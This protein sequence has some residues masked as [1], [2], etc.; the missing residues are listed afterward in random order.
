MN[1]FKN[2]KLLKESYD[3]SQ[4]NFSYDQFMQDNYE[5]LK[6]LKEIKYPE[7]LQLNAD[8]TNARGGSGDYNQN[9]SNKERTGVTDITYGVS[10]GEAGDRRF[11]FSVPGDGWPNSKER[12][13]VSIK[14]DNEGGPT[15]E[16]LESVPAKDRLKMLDVKVK[17]DCP[18]FRWNGPEHRAL[19][20][21]YLD[22]QPY[23]TAS[24]PIV[25]DP[26][27]EY[28]ICK[29]IAYVFKLIDNKFRQPISYYK[30]SQAERS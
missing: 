24:E 9:I 15:P 12:Y 14:F 19:T 20:D 2:W 10:A 1:H 7:L 11:I 29:H 16:E 6:D 21:G 25:R 26:N 27:G 4:S 8:I 3:K 22:G 17:C 28:Y 23:G 5:T 18:F 13:T 30:A